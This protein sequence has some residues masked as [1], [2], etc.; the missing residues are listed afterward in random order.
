METRVSASETD[1]WNLGEQ[2]QL[3]A[4]IELST[5]LSRLSVSE[6]VTNSRVPSA[7]RRIL[8]KMQ[9]FWV[10]LLHSTYMLI[11]K[12]S[13]RVHAAFVTLQEQVTHFGGQGRGKDSIIRQGRNSLESQIPWG[14][15]QCVYLFEKKM[16][17]YIPQTITGSPQTITGSPWVSLICS[18]HGREQ[19]IPTGFR[20]HLGCYSEDST[21]PFPVWNRA[22]CHGE[23]TAG[24]KGVV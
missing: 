14:D 8:F 20:T 11:I 7:F 10:V 15:R 24:K 13:T 22:Y 3:S 5:V 2:Q 4:T 19:G 12:I 16:N 6:N 9:T 18:R 21:R 23:E 1:T 17:L